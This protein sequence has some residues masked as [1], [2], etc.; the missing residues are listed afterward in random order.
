MDAGKLVPMVLAMR[1]QIA[2]N[3][4]QT[5][6]RQ[7]NQARL[8]RFSAR[9]IFAC[10]YSAVTVHG[11]LLLQSFVV[12]GS[13]SSSKLRTA[14]TTVAHPTGISGSQATQ[15]CAQLTKS[16][17]DDERDE[18]CIAEAEE[19]DDESYCAVRLWN[20]PSSSFLSVTS[21]GTIDNF[22]SFG[23]FSILL[24]LRC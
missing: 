21:A 24:R 16:L 12:A 19:N 11:V 7:S 22:F 9:L 10:V 8:T 17:L 5:S 23:R 14:P 15:P 3:G 4:F 13:Q 20:E 1:D 18:A 2:A 6:L